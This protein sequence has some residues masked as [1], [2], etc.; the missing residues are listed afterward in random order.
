MRRSALNLDGRDTEDDVPAQGSFLV[1][2]PRRLVGDRLNLVDGPGLS[3][4]S[5]G[6]GDQDK[7]TGLCGHGCPSFVV[8][9]WI[10]TNT[11][12]IEKPLGADSQGFRQ[13]AVASGAEGYRLE[14]CHLGSLH[15]DRETDLRDCVTWC[16]KML[17]CAGGRFLAPRGFQ[18]RDAQWGRRVN[19]PVTACD[20]SFFFAVYWVACEPGQAE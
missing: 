15:G 12:C 9:P 3:E 20:S 16:L 17:N 7:V 6:L 19:G 11:G 18:L 13:R 4:E 1:E 5:L 8:N 2:A 10:C 14:S